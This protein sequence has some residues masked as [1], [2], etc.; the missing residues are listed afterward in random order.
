MEYHHL[1]NMPFAFISFSLPVLLVLLL[2]NKE[3]R[4]QED[5]AIELKYDVDGR[6]LK[7]ASII[8]LFAL[9]DSRT[10]HLLPSFLAHLRSTRVSN[11]TFRS[12]ATSFSHIFS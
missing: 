7:C 6:L 11:V 3:I 12:E 10:F 2:G 4:T 9:P 1:V 5:S 8:Y